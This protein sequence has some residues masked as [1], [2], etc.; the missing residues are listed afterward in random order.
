MIKLLLIAHLMMPRGS[1]AKYGEFYQYWSLQNSLFIF[2]LNSNIFDGFQPLIM[3][4]DCKIH[5]TDRTFFIF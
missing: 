4:H 1:T 3:S 2:I 5:H